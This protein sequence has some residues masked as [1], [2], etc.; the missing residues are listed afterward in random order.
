MRFNPVPAVTAGFGGRI[1]RDDEQRGSGRGKRR[2]RAGGAGDKE[3]NECAA[4][5]SA[6]EY[7]YAIRLWQRRRRRYETGGVGEQDA[8]SA[9]IFESEHFQGSVG[10][11]IKKDQLF[12]FANYEGVSRRGA[13]E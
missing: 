8:E 7:S 10:G 6:Y 4:H 5:G 1:P 12:F 11:P 2:R 9:A 13:A 3:R